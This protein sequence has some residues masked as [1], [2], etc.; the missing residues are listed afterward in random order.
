MRDNRDVPL[1]FPEDLDDV[2]AAWRLHG[3]A[4]GHSPRT[5]D[6]RCGTIRRLARSCDPL[7]AS[8]EELVGW[9]AGLTNGDAPALRSTKATYRAQIRAFYAWLSDTGRREDDPS[10]KLPATKTPRGVPHPLTPA[11]V[12]AVLKA[13]SDGRSWQTKAYVV[14]GAYAGLRVHEIA[15]VRGEDFHG[16]EIAV[17][18]KGG[19]V[20]TVPMAP[21]IRRLAETMPATGYW[22][23]TRS[24]TG[25][26]HRCSVSA[27]IQRA[28][29]RAGINA[30]PHA[31]RHHYCTQV[32]RASGGDLRTTQR[33][34]RHANPATTAIYTQIVDETLTRAVLGIPGAA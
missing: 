7:R 27:A 14:L 33:A 26:V 5:V 22:F 16:D 23:P 17:I 12:S 29:H 13:C 24:A 30:V 8:R 25:H 11:E 31:L 10:L 3:S 9:L 1:P 2:L 6:A 21:V 19:V 34:A 32:L 4:A 18:G 28:F 20:S 15:K